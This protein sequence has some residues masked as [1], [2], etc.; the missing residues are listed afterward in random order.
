MP[1][2]IKTGKA[3]EYALLAEFYKKLNVTTQQ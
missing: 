2:Q 3:F 1:S